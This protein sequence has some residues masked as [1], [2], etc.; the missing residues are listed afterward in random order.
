MI[1]TGKEQELNATK[2]VKTIDPVSSNHFNFG[3]NT[4]IYYILLLCVTNE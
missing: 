3:K 4:S 2:L 1:F